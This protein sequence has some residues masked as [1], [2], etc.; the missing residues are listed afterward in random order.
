MTVEVT[1]FP[2]GWLN[3]EAPRNIRNILVTEETFQLL[4]SELNDVLFW[5]SSLISVTKLVFQPLI[6]PYVLVA[7]IESAAR[8]ASALRN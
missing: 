2:I 7:A 8:A 5:K 6:S 4:I 1:Q 3:A